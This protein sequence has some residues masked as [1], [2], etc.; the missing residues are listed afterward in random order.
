[1][2]DGGPVSG[3]PGDADESGDPG[4]PGDPGHPGDPRNPGDPGNP[5]GGN[6]GGGNGGNRPDPGNGGQPDPEP[7]PQ[8]PTD[9]IT[10][11]EPT[12]DKT[13]EPNNKTFHRKASGPVTNSGTEPIVIEVKI[14]PIDRKGGS[15]GAQTSTITIAPGETVD[16]A[17]DKVVYNNG[18]GAVVEL[19]YQITVLGPDGKPLADGSLDPVTV[20][21]P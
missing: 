12:A 5:G 16:L 13:K 3:A 10:V 6:G 1:Q 9:Q 15:N 19:E 4:D 7:G 2:T 20:N 17:S 14:I 8:N 11:G 21:H 18:Q